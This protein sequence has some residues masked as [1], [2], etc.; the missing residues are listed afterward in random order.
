MNNNNFIEK[1]SINLKNADIKNGSRLVVAL[2]GGIDSTA[3]LLALGN[4]KSKYNNEIISA[5]FNHS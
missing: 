5:H 2:S 3:L 4:I 1:I